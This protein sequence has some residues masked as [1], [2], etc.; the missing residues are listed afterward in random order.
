[1]EP[2]GIAR[3]GPLNISRRVFAVVTVACKALF[4]LQPNASWNV[5][6]SAPISRNL[7]SPKSTNL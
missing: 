2:P 3:R 7:R 1:M 6:I 5:R 4:N